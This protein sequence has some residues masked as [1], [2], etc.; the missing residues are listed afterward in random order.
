MESVERANVGTRVPSK[1]RYSTGK[2]KTDDRLC[3]APIRGGRRIP[4]HVMDLFP[5]SRAQ[6]LFFLLSSVQDI[7][8]PNKQRVPVF[9]RELG[10]T[11]YIFPVKHAPPDNHHESKSLPRKNE[12]AVSKGG[13]G[14]KFT[15]VFAQEP[16]SYRG[17][18][19]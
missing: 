3:P 11:I 10:K 1:V 17:A 16:R 13:L 7:G 9:E 15:R 14:H 12:W 5:G 19:E 6:T 2:D 18:P 8:K 4:R